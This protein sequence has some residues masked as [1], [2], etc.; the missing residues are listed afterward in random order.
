MN[1]N[2]QKR[3]L[4]QLD[5]LDVSLDEGQLQKLNKYHELLNE[6]GKVMNLTTI[7]D[8]KEVYEKHFLDS[9]AICKIIKMKENLQI[10]DVGTGAGF[11]GI[12][13]KI[14]FPQVKIVLLD[15][16]NK[17]I[18]FL[19]EVIEK[20]GL[21][22]IETIHGRAEDFAKMEGYREAFDVS[23]SRAVA[24]LSTLAEYCV[25]YVCIGGSFVSYKAGDVY[26]EI[27]VAQRAIKELGGTVDEILMFQLP[28]TEIQRSFVKIQKICSTPAKYPR[29]AGLPGKEPLTE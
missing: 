10:I 8:E 12:P 4:L 20:L 21:T 28:D 22:N 29:K 26:E 25:P 11:P 16:L 2:L 1:E 13:I 14:A 3:F 27:E 15:S 18:K 24:N 5:E 23:V 19:D 6:R 9:L 7:T 17:R